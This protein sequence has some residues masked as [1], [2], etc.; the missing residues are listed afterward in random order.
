[1]KYK[2]ELIKNTAIISIGRLSTQIVSFLLLPLYTSLLTTRDYGAL[3]FLIVLSTFLLPI[4][5]LNMEESMFRFLIDAKDEQEKRNI[6]SQTLSFIL[7]SLFIFL[8]V[9]L[10]L[11]KFIDYQY[12]YY[13]IFYIITNALSVT[14]LAIVRGNG[15][16][17]LYSLISFVTSF[18]TIIL[19]V[20][21][22]VALRTG[23]KG[24]M[25]SD[26]IA[27]TIS[28][29]ILIIILNKKKYVKLARFDKNKLVDMLKYSI[30]LVPNSIAFNIINLSDRFVVMAIL[31]ASANGVYS[32]SNKFPSILNTLYSFF[33]IAWKESAAKII[34]DEK[35]SI[36]YNSIYKQL[37]NFL[38]G[39]SILLICVLPFV[40]SILVNAN[41]ADAYNYIPILILAMYFS[42]ISG[43]YGGI[44]AAFK[45]TKIMGTTTMIGAIANLTI[46]LVFVKCVGLYASAISTL[47]A[48]FLMFI[49]RKKELK[50]YIELDKN[51]NFIFSMLIIILV[52][53]CY[54]IRSL[55]LH[56]VSLGI[57]GIYFCFINKNIF[58][59]ITNKIKR[60]EVANI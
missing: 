29:L 16:L 19:N 44:F 43:Y 53:I 50:K 14:L 20:T 56:L 26:I 46:N 51:N 59:L 36:Y 23:V 6:I 17:K 9:A 48:C 57:G 1:M 40:F 60:K 30:P 34:K 15:N 49:V 21:F 4:I 13:L 31:G 38:I 42:N 52:T 7:T 24:L 55:P 25:L 41:F 47:V 39:I 22:I 5:R 11:F 12:A 58:M 27:H 54:Y 33:Y 8:I 3:D 10:I 45:T 35:K 32:I 18:F 28:V 37:N 2:K